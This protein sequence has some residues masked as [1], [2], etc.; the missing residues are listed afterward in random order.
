M[1]NT[2]ISASRNIGFH[3]SLLSKF[4]LCFVVLDEHNSEMDR[5]FQ[6]EL[7]IIIC[8]QMMHQIY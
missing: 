1:V 5:K 3:D 4:D 6:K 2:D 7:L 8:L